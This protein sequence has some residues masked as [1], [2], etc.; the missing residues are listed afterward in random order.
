MNSIVINST[1][2]QIGET[3]TILTAC[4]RSDR[5]NP[6]KV[7]K[8]KNLGQGQILIID[9]SKTMQRPLTAFE[10]ESE[11]WIREN[12]ANFSNAKNLTFCLPR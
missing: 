10:S 3:K 6:A 8:V 2:I 9:G 11:H 7:L 5:Y 4:T 12:T 1:P